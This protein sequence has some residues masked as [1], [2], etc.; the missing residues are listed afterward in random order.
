MSF[1]AEEI[2][3]FDAILAE[4]Y[5]SELIASVWILIL[6]LAVLVILPFLPKDKRWRDTPLLDDGKEPRY[7]NGKKLSRRE[8]EAQRSQRGLRGERI[9]G[10]FRAVIWAVM[11]SL[12]V[13]FCV[14]SAVS[15]RD[16]QRDM[17][18]NAYVIHEGEFRYEYTFGGRNSSERAEITFTDATGKTVT[19]RIH[20][21]VYGYMEDGLYTG[22]V[23]YAQGCGYAIEVERDTSE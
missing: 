7:R 6:L 11:L 17:D 18:E 9:G 16:I 14:F 2:A 8:R 22:R 4:I 3:R 1:T 5:E 21:P 13:I 23:V 10:A 15:L 12:T 19:V 20:D